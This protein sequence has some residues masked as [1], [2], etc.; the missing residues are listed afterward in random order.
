M[1]QWFSEYWHLALML[2]GLCVVAAVVFFFAGKA[3]MKYVRNY[4]QQEEEIKRLTELKNKYIPLTEEKLS[5]GDDEEILE[6]ASLVYQIAFEKSE[7][8]E[9]EF[10]K[11]TDVQKNIYAL[12]IFVFDKTATKF[13]TFNDTMLR[14]RLYPALE[15]IG[16]DVAMDEFRHINDMYDENNDDVSLDMKKLLQLD[17]LIEKKDILR[18]I[19]LSAAEYIK[20][21]LELL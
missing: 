20:S 2:A 18:K 12:D 3:R 15:M 4:K 13:F 21:N 11:L 5:R 8:P 9:Q 16:F 14:S 6:A 7:Y 17:E 1:A 10:K 19:K